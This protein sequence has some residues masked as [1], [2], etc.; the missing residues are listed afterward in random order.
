MLRFISGLLHQAA[1]TVIQ[2]LRGNYL[3]STQSLS[4]KSHEMKN[5]VILGGSYAGI[6]TAHRILKQA[7]T[8]SFKISLVSPNTHLYW[9]VASPRGILPGQLADDR[10]FLPIASGF[11]RHSSDRFELILGTAEKVNVDAKTV[12]IST[13]QGKQ[14]LS[15]DILVLATGSRTDGN[16]PFKNLGS[17]EATRDAVHDLQERVAKA[18][19]IVVGGAGVT[20]VEISGEL[21]FEYKR[22]K[23]I[24]LVGYTPS[25][26]SI[27]SL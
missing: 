7:K 14:T 12:E 4:P 19:T 3:E 1:A 25:P 16:T 11:A 9:N 15:Y 10:L 6:S 8:S 17:T 24:I 22:K 13:S 23:E 5:I 21:S 18:K 26:G 20:G 2:F 27:I